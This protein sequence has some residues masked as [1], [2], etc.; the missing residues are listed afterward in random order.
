MKQSVQIKLLERQLAATQQ[1]LLAV[2]EELV[3][4]QRCFDREREERQRYQV[5]VS[6]LRKQRDQLRSVIEEYD[7]R[8]TEAR[9]Q[10]LREEGAHGRL[11]NALDDTKH[12]YQDREGN[13]T[14]EA[15]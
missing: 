12:C 15:G 4:C 3:R 11:L 9:Y 2:R 1:E 13:L 7:E 5:A 14:K 10:R 8:R 6:A